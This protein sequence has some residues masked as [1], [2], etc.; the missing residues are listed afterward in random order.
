MY[1]LI[2]NII[3]LLT[4]LVVLFFIYNKQK[5]CEKISDE[6]LQISSKNIDFVSKLFDKIEISIIK[7]N[8]QL[9]SYFQIILKISKSDYISY[10]KYYY[11]QKQIKLKFMVSLESNGNIIQNSIL[12]NLPITSNILLLD[13]LKS[14]NNIYSITDSQIE[15]KNNIVYEVLKKREIKKIYYYN[16]YKNNINFPDGFLILSYKDEK[17]E[18]VDSDK[19]EIFRLIEKMKKFI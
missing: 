7:N 13:I 11:S 9:V 3:F 14:D 15:E 2:I 8:I 16:I 10:F 6:F 5:K 1:Y 18:L 12:D 17:Y 4:I 19:K